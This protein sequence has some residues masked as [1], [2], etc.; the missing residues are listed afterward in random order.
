MKVI[1]DRRSSPLKID[2]LAGFGKLFAD[3]PK[4]TGGDAQRT[5]FRKGTE[6][7][8]TLADL[9]IDRKPSSL[10]DLDAQRSYGV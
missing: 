9:G 2:A 5:R 8:A 4:A 7:R 1:I 10:L 6:S 3:Q